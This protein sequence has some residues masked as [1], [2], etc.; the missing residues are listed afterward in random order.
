VERVLQL[1]G[2]VRIP[3]LPWRGLA[4]VAVVAMVLGGG[5]LWFRDSSF[6]KVQ[7]VE[8][9][10][11]S[12]SEAPA[13][14]RALDATARSMTTLHLDRTSLEDAVA[15]YPSVAGLRIQTDFPHGVSIEVTEREPIAEVDLAGDVVPVGAGGRL[16]RGVKPMRKLPV[17]HAT[18]LAPGGRL[19]DPDALAA[20]NVL[21]AAPEALRRKVSRIWSGP[22]GLSLD[23][24]AGPELF[25]GSADRPVAKWM[26][27]ARVLAESSAEGA[28]Y[29]D[30]RVPERVAAGGLGTRPAEEADPLAPTA[31][32]QILDPQAQ[33]ETTA[34]LNP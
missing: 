6:F 22:K 10:G 16:M 4:V 31:Q 15:A 2:S 23:L 24:R 32:G 21:A 7:R 19:T 18:H 14:R 33:P 34:T 1:T 5:F 26:A 9:I 8:V 13:V 30:V 20:V 11:L 25:F 27:T 12:S 17:L 3:A 29:L 28:V